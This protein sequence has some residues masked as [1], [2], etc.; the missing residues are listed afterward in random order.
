MIY[1]DYASYT[2]TNDAVLKK[3][4]DIE[5]QFFGSA[6]SQHQLGQEAYAK[7][8]NITTRIS[9]LLQVAPSEIIYTSGASEGNNLAIK[10]IAK[11]YAFKG[12]H[13]LSTSLEHPSVTGTLSF[14]QEQGYDIELLKILS[15]GQIDIQ[16]L[17]T[18]IRPDTILMCVSLIDSEL[19]AIQPIDE[20]SKI[21]EKYPYCHLHIDVAQAMG[22]IPV[23]MNNA[24]T[25]TFSPNKF[26]GICGTGV[27]V[28]RQDVILEP[29]IH[30]GASTNIYRSGTPSL[31]LA[32][33]TLEALEIAIRDLDKNF[34]KVSQLRNYLIDELSTIPLVRFNSP[35]NA[36]PYILN[37]SVDGIRGVDFRDALN[38]KNVFV[39][40]KSACSTDSS[41]SRP[42]MAVSRN[43][44]NA[45]NS[46]RISLS[47]LTT[48]EELEE[49]I[50]I[51]KSI[52]PYPLKDEKK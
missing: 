47:H 51:F 2:P 27:L 18:A 35:K 15:D 41:P 34:C 28:K 33:S 42:V 10:G 37:L 24:A 21:L 7:I 38:A 13:I 45:L 14:L 43:K 4:C 5:K 12:K 50:K 44:K 32:A 39:S 29:L 6:L 23:S 25:L 31:A 49:F 46:W 52:L 30:G 40:V 8:E 17:K 1:L 22:K 16:H 11:T 19:G 48:Q 3:F 20:I 36:S 26:Y 9:T